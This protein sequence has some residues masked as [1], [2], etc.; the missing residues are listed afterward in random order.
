MGEYRSNL[1]NRPYYPVNV[2]RSYGYVSKL[3]PRRRSLSVHV[4]VHRRNLAEPLDVRLESNH[5]HHPRHAVDFSR[6]E[7]H[8]G[9]GSQMI[10]ELTRVCAFDRP[11]AGVVNARRH[12]VR[13]KPVGCLE[14]LDGKNT[15]VVELIEKPSRVLLG[16]R[17]QSGGNALRG[18][19][20]K[21]KNSLIVMILN[22][23]IEPDVTAQ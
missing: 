15:N 13:K 2:I 17:L 10:L 19:D 4:N 5:V 9:H 3:S 11:M 14:K 21:A 12:L 8:A 23:R 18:R 16:L 6:A 20:R 7:L 1:G 22:E